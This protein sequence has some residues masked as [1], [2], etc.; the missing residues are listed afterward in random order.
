MVKNDNGNIVFTGT[1]LRIQAELVQSL[2][3][4]HEMVASKSDKKFADN[5][6]ESFMETAK[7]VIGN[8]YDASGL[9]RDCFVKTMGEKKEN[10]D[11]SSISKEEVETAMNFIKMIFDKME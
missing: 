6:T 1:I 5:L 4:F 11:T 10:S 9:A 8:N 3:S 2:V 7:K